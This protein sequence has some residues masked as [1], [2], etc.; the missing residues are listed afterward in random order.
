MCSDHIWARKS[1]GRLVGNG[2]TR[3][4]DD[5]DGAVKALY[6]PFQHVQDAGQQ[7]LIADREQ[8]LGDVWSEGVETCVLA[9]CQY[10][11]LEIHYVYLFKPRTF[12]SCS[13]F[14]DDEEQYVCTPF[15]GL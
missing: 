9:A 1:L 4:S 11:H 8:H 14:T 13:P 6:E 5:E 15:I 3:G 7:R 10:H 2:R 12:S